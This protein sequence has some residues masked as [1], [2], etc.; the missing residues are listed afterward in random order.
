MPV[1]TDNFSVTLFSFIAQ[2][3]QT[4]YFILH[5]HSSVS[6]QQPSDFGLQHQQCL[7]QMDWGENNR[8]LFS[9]VPSINLFYNE[10]GILI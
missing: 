4:Y 1:T 3:H 2:R 6:Y 10:A 9:H 8:H 7:K 5:N